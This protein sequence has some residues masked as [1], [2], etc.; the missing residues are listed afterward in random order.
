MQW[1]LNLNTSHI[2]YRSSIFSAT[3]II[4]LLSLI[5]ISF[6][7]TCNFD[8]E[9]YKSKT[10]YRE[11]HLNQSSAT[12]KVIFFSLSSTFYCSQNALEECLDDCHFA[13]MRCNTGRSYIEKC[14]EDNALCRSD[15]RQNHKVCLIPT[16]IF[17]APSQGMQHT[18]S[19]Y[20]LHTVSYR[21]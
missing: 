9:P 18:Q 4:I 6:Q 3:N 20:I 12:C 2:C 7:S 21:L 13:V 19:Y 11:R 17:Y 15:C 8:D 14:D 5:R 16:Q 10:L 1:I